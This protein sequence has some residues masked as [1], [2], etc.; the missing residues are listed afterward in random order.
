[1]TAK[2]YLKQALMGASTKGQYVHFRYG[3]SYDAIF[4]PNMIGQIIAV[5]GP[6]SD[7]D[8]STR[9]YLGIQKLELYPNYAADCHGM[10]TNNSGGRI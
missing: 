4:D 9:N 10:R 1:M 5:T 7:M 6:V 8:T 2:E 3:G